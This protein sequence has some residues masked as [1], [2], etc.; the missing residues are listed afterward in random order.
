MK[1]LGQLTII[2]GVS[3]IGEALRYFIPLPIPASIYGL[4]L[5]LILLCT[6][7]IKVSSVKETSSFLLEIMPL[8]LI[9]AGAGVVD[10]WD[11]IRPILIPCILLYI[12]ATVIVMAVTGRVTQG[13][14][15]RRKR[16]ADNNA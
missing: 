1:Y 12:V 4:I 11:V 13:I 5:M 2:L 14:I 3:F 7:V 10:N 9:P 16:K 6:G 8:L 15:R